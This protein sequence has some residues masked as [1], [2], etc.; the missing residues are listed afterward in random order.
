[1]KSLVHATTSSFAGF[2]LA[3][4]LLAI[5]APIARA[6]DSMR[7]LIERGSWK[8]VRAIAE[9]RLA[10]NPSD[11]EA[12]WLMSQ[13]KQAFGDVKAAMEYAEKA[14]ALD[15]S[16]ADYHLQLAEVVGQKAQKAGPIKGIG[17]GKKFRKE[18][19]TAIKLDPRQID[20]R[21]DMMMF[22]REAP[23]IIGGDNKKAKAQADEIFKL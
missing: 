15:G 14:V 20:A 6:D 8:K 21:F 9:P 16:N 19:E 5:V 23:G 7:A 11:P 17:L 18:A 22:Y 12:L 13:V 4:A 10:A 2:A 3:V 1:M